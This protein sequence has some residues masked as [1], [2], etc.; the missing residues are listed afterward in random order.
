MT[1]MLT[2]PEQLMLSGHTGK[3]HTDVRKGRQDGWVTVHPPESWINPKERPQVLR[4]RAAS[5][6]S[7]KSV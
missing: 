7:A 4:A 5:S 3:P 6:M 2:S 1:S